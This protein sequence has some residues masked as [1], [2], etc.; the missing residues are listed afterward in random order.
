MI[1]TKQ[2]WNN[3]Y[4]EVLIH[5]NW[6]HYTALSHPWFVPDYKDGG[7]KGYATMQNLLKRN[8]P[9]VPCDAKDES[10]PADRDWETRM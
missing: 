3:G 10:G 9:L 6:V 2:R 7:S 5:G 4:L 8:V 1:P